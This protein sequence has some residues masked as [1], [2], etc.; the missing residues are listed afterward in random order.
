MDAGRAVF[1]DDAQLPSVR[2]AVDFLLTNL[3]WSLEA[4]GSEGEHHEWFVLRTGPAERLHRPF[5]EF[6][7]F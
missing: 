3:D 2:K 4:K 1:V 6:V 5:A 7:D